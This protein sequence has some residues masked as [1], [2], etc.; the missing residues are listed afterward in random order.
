MGRKPHKYNTRS[1]S[2]QQNN[3]NNQEYDGNNN[4]IPTASNIQNEKEELMNI[5]EEI[6]VP[7]VPGHNVKKRALRES[8]EL[9]SE[10]PI[11]NVVKPGPSMSYVAEPKDVVTG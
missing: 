2:G 7:R 5:E 6:K 8:T 9:E 10:I 3:N 11:S 1:T 4:F